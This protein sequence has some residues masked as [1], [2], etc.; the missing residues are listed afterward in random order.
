MT[1]AATAAAVVERLPHIYSSLL[2][3]HPTL[4]LIDV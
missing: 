3:L 4:E 2:R 1:D